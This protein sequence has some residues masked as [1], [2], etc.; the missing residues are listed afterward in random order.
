[1]SENRDTRAIFNASHCADEFD[2]IHA[3]HMFLQSAFQFGFFMV[4]TLFFIP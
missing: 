3:G 2:L 1:M 4:E